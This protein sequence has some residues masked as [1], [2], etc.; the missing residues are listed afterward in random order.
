RLVNELLRPTGGGDVGHFPAHRAG[1]PL[2]RRD[3]LRR[4]DDLLVNVSPLLDVD[5]VLVDRNAD[6]LTFPTD[7]RH[8]PLDR[9]IDGMTLDRDLFATDWNLKRPLLLDHFLANHD[10]ANLLAVLV[11]LDLLVSERNPTGLFLHGA[12]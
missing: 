1:D 11:N 6:H 4:D 5:H 7:W 8:R 10:F 12:A 3:V 9:A 2:L